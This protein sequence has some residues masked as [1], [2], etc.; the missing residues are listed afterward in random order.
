MIR[1][2]EHKTKM[3][4]FLAGESHEYISHDAFPLTLEHTFL[5]CVQE[6][7]VLLDQES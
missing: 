6:L 4:Y 3:S 7:E 5:E 1:K 2:K